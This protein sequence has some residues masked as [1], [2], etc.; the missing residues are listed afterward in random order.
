MLGGDEDVGRLGDRAGGLQGLRVSQANG[1]LAL[2][3]RAERLELRVRLARCFERLGRA[4]GGEEDAREDRS[5]GGAER[6]C[7]IWV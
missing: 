4:V 5:G 7:S 1:G 2:F 3:E 6:A